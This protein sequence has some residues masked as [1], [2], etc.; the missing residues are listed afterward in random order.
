MSAMRSSYALRSLVVAFAGAAVALFACGKAEN[1]ELLPS[2]DGGQSLGGDGGTLPDDASTR[3]C[4]FVDAGP[5][6]AC[7]GNGAPCVGAT[8]CCSSRCEGN[9]CLAAGSCAA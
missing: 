1:V 5:R 4:D 7:R 3:P 9:M 8:D 2:S 6:Q